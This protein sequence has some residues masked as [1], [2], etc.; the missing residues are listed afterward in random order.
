MMNRWDH[1]RTYPDGKK[2]QGIF[3]GSKL[4]ES[5]NITP[6]FSEEEVIRY[7]NNLAERKKRVT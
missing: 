6:Q 1:V 5:R 7:I 2:I 3:N 4:V